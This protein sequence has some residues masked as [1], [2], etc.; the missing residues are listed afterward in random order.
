MKGNTTKN[1]EIP[2][3]PLLHKKFKNHVHKN[4]KIALLS[5][6]MTDD[7]VMVVKKP[8]TAITRY[9]IAGV[10]KEDISIYIYYIFCTE[11]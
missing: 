6:D 8:T 1:H 7:F 3:Y 5:I 11:C 2:V 10:H 4:M 9:T